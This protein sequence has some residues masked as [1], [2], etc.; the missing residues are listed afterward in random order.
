[1]T[2]NRSNVRLT[3]QSDL[4]I[5]EVEIY[6]PVPRTSWMDRSEHNIDLDVLV[7]WSNQSIYFILKERFTH[8]SANLRMKVIV[9]IL[10]HQLFF[11]DTCFPLRVRSRTLCAQWTCHVLRTRL[12]RIPVSCIPCHRLVYSYVSLPSYMFS[13]CTDVDCRL[14]TG[15]LFV[16]RFPF[17]IV[18]S[19]TYVL[20]LRVSPFVSSTRP[21]L[22]ITAYAFLL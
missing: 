18:D 20:R 11:T 14:V 2:V 4:Y 9:T 22:T 10:S 5:F 15:Y 17:R 12:S 13:Y 19:C 21:M 8:L 6:A 16:S 3:Y 1:M 7:Y